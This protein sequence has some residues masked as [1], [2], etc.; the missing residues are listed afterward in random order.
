MLQQNGR[1]RTVAL[2]QASTTACS[3]TPWTSGRTIVSLIS[4]SRMGPFWNESIGQM[5]SSYPSSSSPSSSATCAPRPEKWN[6]RESPSLLP[7]TSHCIPNRMLSLVGSLNGSFWSSVS[8]MMQ[9]LG[10]AKRWQRSCLMHLTSLRAPLSWPQPRR[11]RDADQ[12]GPLLAAGAREARGGRRRRRP[13]DPPPPDTR[14][15]AALRALDG[16]LAGA[17]GELRAAVLAPDCR[18]GH[19][20]HVHGEA[21]RAL[22]AL[23]TLLTARC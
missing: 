10:K 5:A 9:S 15:A 17:H 19:P 11:V 12:E 20:T 1:S 22:V 18:R 7:S 14:H 13:L 6:T 21:S 23:P 8:M 4:S 16:A 2:W 3:L